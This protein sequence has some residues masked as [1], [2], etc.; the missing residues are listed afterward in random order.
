M[1]PKV[2]LSL[3]HQRHAALRRE[4]PARLARVGGVSWSP[5]AL[6]GLPARVR[7]RTGWLLVAIGLRLA[8]SGET[9]SRPGAD[10]S[11]VRDLEPSVAER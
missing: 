8:L 1:N 10:R 11:D 4:T 5:A 9:A 2:A 6:P 3:A 7:R